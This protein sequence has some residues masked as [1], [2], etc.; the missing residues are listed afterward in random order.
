MGKARQ[1][2]NFRLKTTLTLFLG[3]KEKKRNAAINERKKKQQEYLTAL[4]QVKDNNLIQDLDLYI[5]SNALELQ[6]GSLS[7]F[8][9]R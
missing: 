9:T 4:N 6:F 5:L 3:S 7:E 1:G 8:E 2:P